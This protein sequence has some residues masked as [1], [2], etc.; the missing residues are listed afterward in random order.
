[1]NAAR[2]TIQWLAIALAGLALGACQDASPTTPQAA[3][4][5]SFDRGGTQDHFNDK[6]TFTGETVTDADGTTVENVTI[7]AGSKA[8][9]NGDDTTC[10]YFTAGD[11]YLG[12]FRSL[13]FASDD[14]ATVEQF[15]IDNFADRTT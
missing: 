10:S 8:S 15:C 7:Q 4:A 3:I 11:A 14:A 12:Q 1:M 9:N 13:S 5:P 2:P 6:F